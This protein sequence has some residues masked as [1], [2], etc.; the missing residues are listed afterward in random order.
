MDPLRK[1]SMGHPPLIHPSH[2]FVLTINRT[3][4]Q[5]VLESTK[6]RQG[7]GGRQ[8]RG[9][10]PQPAGDDV[11]STGVVIVCTHGEWGGDKKGKGW[12]VVSLKR[13]QT[14]IQQTIPSTFLLLLMDKELYC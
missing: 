1:S 9:R 8:G 7:E 12:P 2:S 3:Q 5:H 11:F 13:K 14:R 10:V 4:V 6:G